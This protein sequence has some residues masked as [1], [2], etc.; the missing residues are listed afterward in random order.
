M[1][2][3]VYWVSESVVDEWVQLPDLSPK[4]L[5]DSRKVKVLFSGNLER[6]IIT[7]PF[8]KGKEKNYLRA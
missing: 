1:N 5:A 8:F 6:E 3:N 7:N 4:D 2:Q